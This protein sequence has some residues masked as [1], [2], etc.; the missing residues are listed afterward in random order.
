MT[1]DWYVG[2][3]AVGLQIHPFSKSQGQFVLTVS[4]CRDCLRVRRSRPRYFL[5]MASC[6]N[7]TYVRN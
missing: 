4:A 3:A 6:H 7:A 1:L 5:P 2:R